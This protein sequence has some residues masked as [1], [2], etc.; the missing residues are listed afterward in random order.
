MEITNPGKFKMPSSMS[1]LFIL[2]G[3]AGIGSFVFLLQLDSDR[4]WS[5]FVINHF[6]FLCL[7]VGGIFFAALQ[8]VTNAMWSAPIRRLCEA[9]TGYLPFVFI[10][11]IVLFLGLH[12]IYH[13]THIEVV[14]NDPI[15]QG[16]SGYLNSTFFIIRNIVAF[17]IW[18]FF[19]KKMISNST[20]QDAD[21]DFSHTQKNRILGPIFLILF[22]LSFTMSSFDQI[23]SLDPHWFSTI[24][25]VYTF[26]G[27]FYSTLA[28]LALITVYMRR[29]GYLKGIVNDNHLHDI[30]KFMFA[31][32]VF[33]AYIAFSQF[34]LIWYAN[35]P[36]ETGYYLKRFQ[37]NWMYVSVFLL[38]GKFLVPFF[39]LLPREAKRSESRLVKVAI[40]MLFAHW[41]DVLWMVQPEFFSTGPVIGILEVI[42]TLGFFGIFSLM[43]F[44]FLTKNN[45]VA[46]KDPRLH[47]AVTHHHQ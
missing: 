17:L 25:G 7:A 11:S 12:S 21:G 1:T 3:L 4:A 32:T 6:Y 45:V 10:T 15:L 16:K 9:F 40:F 46:I 18:F 2:L 23:M 19:A 29:K 13:W 33:W 36:E 24:F 22:S 44:R 42:V 20:A 37:G 35:L 26:A 5:I 43:T 39:A 28:A 27:L 30:G 41:V 31:F 34:M 14:A 38:L 8:W 47:E